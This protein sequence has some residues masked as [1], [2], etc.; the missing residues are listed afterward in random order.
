MCGWVLTDNKYIS[1]FWLNFLKV[2][3]KNNPHNVYSH[4]W[5][6]ISKEKYQPLLAQYECK[7]WKNQFN[8]AMRLIYI[9]IWL[10]EQMYCICVP[11]ISLLTS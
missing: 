2:E 4:F 3:I 11:L 7:N 6:I 1:L 5:L 9:Y 8:E 10:F